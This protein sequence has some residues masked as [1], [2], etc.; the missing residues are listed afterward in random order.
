M[1]AA[2]SLSLVAFVAHEVDNIDVLMAQGAFTNT[3]GI[4]NEPGDVDLEITAN[5]MA[6]GTRGDLSGNGEVTAYDAALIL[7]RLV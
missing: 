4:P 6:L 1:P 5:C 3:D 7:Q 2:M